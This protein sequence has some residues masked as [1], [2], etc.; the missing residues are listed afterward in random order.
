MRNNAARAFEAEASF[1]EKELATVTTAETANWSSQVS[2]EV[3]LGNA[4]VKLETTG[5]FPTWATEAVE[6][7]NRA[8][9]LPQNWDS[10]GARPVTQRTLEHALLVL[11]KIMEPGFRVPRILATSHGGIQFTWV[12]GDKE[13]E[14]TV[15][16]PLRGQFYFVDDSTGEEEEDNIG[17][18]YSALSPYVE[19]VAR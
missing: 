3:T 16:A 5:D 12:A 19:Q 7:L 17:I 13:L 14:I 4:H 6:R 10:Y 8:A 9:A 11:T 18:N 2:K 15:D 1:S